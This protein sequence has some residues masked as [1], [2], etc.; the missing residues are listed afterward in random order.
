MAAPER[1]S[2]GRRNRQFSMPLHHSNA[3]RP[4]LG[5]AQQRAPVALFGVDLHFDILG[6][7]MSQYETSWINGPEIRPDDLDKPCRQVYVWI[8]TSDDHVVVVSKDGEHWQ[9][10]GGKPDPSEALNKAAVREV[11]EETGLNIAGLLGDLRF[12]GYRV[13]K[14]LDSE[15]P[16]YLQARYLL[17][18]DT[19]AAALEFDL[20]HED[21]DQP[22]ADVIRHVGAVSLA[23]LISRMPWLEDSPELNAVTSARTR[24]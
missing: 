6:M 16:P 11:H 8:F 3:R 9:L 19:E 17:E 4:Y 22:E 2:S 5:Y 14:E 24:Q 7:H 12:F 13:V 23:E 1:L 10:P 20:G 21:E 15:E 18:L